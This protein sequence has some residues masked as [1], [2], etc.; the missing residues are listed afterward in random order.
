MGIEKSKII[1]KK[2]EKVESMENIIQLNSKHKI[3]VNSSHNIPKIFFK[4]QQS[5]NFFPIVTQKTMN[6]SSKIPK[7]MVS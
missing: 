7:F 5:P 3:D 2:D 6:F 4:F 1:M